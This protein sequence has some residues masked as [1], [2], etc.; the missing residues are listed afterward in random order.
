MAD[1]LDSFVVLFR[2][3][4]AMIGAEVPAEKNA[5]LIKIADELKLDKKVFARIAKYAADEE[6]W[7]ESE[8][9]ETFGAY[10]KLLE[11]VIQTVNQQPE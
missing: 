9:N 10:L 7:L 6:V 2:H 4:L 11:R 3:V 1:S 5:T 8:I